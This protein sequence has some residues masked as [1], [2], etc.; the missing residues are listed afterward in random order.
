MG[1]PLTLRFERATPPPR[2]DGPARSS[3]IHPSELDDDPL[4]QSVVKRFEAR[5]VKVEMD[6]GGE[7]S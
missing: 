4:V 2:P 1:R 3:S 7:G 6:E 5:A